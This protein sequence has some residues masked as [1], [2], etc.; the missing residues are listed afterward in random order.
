MFIIIGWFTRQNVIGVP[1]PQPEEIIEMIWTS[2]GN[3]IY[4]KFINEI[5]SYT[6]SKDMFEAYMNTKTYGGIVTPS[7]EAFIILC[8]KNGYKTWKYDVDKEKRNRMYPNESANNE[9]ID[10][11]P[12]FEFTHRTPLRRNGGWT[13]EGMTLFTEIDA[14]IRHRRQANKEYEND[15]KTWYTRNSSVCLKRKRELESH[16]LCRINIPDD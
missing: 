11:K 1:P 13:R 2:D 7:Q 9:R 16:P 6:V 8:Y 5:V 15:F 3:Y 10:Q 12:K 14:K 4:N